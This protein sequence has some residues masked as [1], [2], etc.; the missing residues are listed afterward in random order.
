MVTGSVRAAH[1]AATW[2]GTG[3]LIRV[4]MF[5]LTQAELERESRYNPIDAFYREGAPR[6]PQSN[7]SRTD[8][9]DRIV[10]GRFP[11]VVRLSGRNRSRWFTAYVEQLI[12]RD[13]EQISARA[14]RPA[15]LRAVF[16]SSVARTGQE[17]NKNGTAE[18]AGVD[19]R[20]ADYYLELLED[21][22][23]IFRVPAWHTSRLKRLTLSPKV[24]VA[25][26][27]MAAHVL[28]VDAQALGNSP[29][30]VGQL[31]ETFV[32]AEL[33]THLET[34]NEE[35]D[36]F[37]LRSR[38]GREVDVLLERRGR[39][40]GLEVKSATAVDRSDAKGL[41]WL[42]NQL[43]T[44]FHYGA[45][46]YSGSIPFEIDDRIWALPISSL[47]RKPLG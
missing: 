43:G 4:R 17:L 46:L 42:R 36:L 35:T 44:D 7:L 47:W 14:T 2:P 1:Q 24:H 18:D 5:G 22:S 34:T 45:V 29:G 21:L 11:A 13:A 28:R 12:D 37:H 6:F 40:V 32:V 26:P 8:Y 27:G 16:A 19:F 3:R 9:L 30:L 41:L 25:D 38:D 23:V 33:R 39:V 31:F 15:K 20:S 10:A